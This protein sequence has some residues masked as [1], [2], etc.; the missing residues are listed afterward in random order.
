MAAL[1]ENGCISSGYLPISND[2]PPEKDH[3]NSLLRNEKRPKCSLFTGHQ[4]NESII[5]QEEIVPK[6]HAFGFAPY[7]K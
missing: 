1:P 2:W 7:K 6:S 4:S 3:E 5:S